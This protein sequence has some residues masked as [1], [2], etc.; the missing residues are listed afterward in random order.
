MT[1]NEY[2]EKL[3]KQITILTNKSS[4][5]ECFSSNLPF[6]ETVKEEEK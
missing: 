6:Y 5:L 2:K 4:Y 1:T 3:E